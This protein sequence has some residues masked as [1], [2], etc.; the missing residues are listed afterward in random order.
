MIDYPKIELHC[1]T[2]QRYRRKA[3]E[4]F[5]KNR[6][7]EDLRKGI[8]DPCKDYVSSLLAVNSC[9]SQYFAH[10]KEAITG[11]PCFKL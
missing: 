5:L 9:L 7:S 8:H 2:C 10:K 1:L 11:E 3:E 4:C 6:N